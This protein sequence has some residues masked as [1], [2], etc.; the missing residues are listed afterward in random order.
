MF[1]L[2]KRYLSTF[3]REDVEIEGDVLCFVRSY[4]RPSRAAAV[5]PA[6]RPRVRQIGLFWREF[7]GGNL[8]TDTNVFA[9]TIPLASTVE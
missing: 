4:V 7:F 1:F 3:E 2:A 8:M 6:T 5:T 9:H